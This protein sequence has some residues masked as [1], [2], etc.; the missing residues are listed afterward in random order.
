[1]IDTRQNLLS[2][3]GG[4]AVRSTVQE[5]QDFSQIGLV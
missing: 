3:M 2:G 5:L 4:E 1:M